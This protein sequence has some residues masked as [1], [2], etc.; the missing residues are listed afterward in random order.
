MFF[1]IGA[2]SGD[3]PII[4]DFR[5]MLD[6]S[7]MDDGHSLTN[8]LLKEKETTTVPNNEATHMYIRHNHHPRVTPHLLVILTTQT[9]MFTRAHAWRKP[10]SQLASGCRVGCSMG[11]F[12]CTSGLIPVHPRGCSMQ[13]V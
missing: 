6:K 5:A 11:Q 10:T 2:G 1:Y 4:V 13:F 7:L 8:A 12:V 3:A 9:S